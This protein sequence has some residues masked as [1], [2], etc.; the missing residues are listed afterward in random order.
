M[1]ARAHEVCA[2]EHHRQVL[3][4]T[5]SYESYEFHEFEVE[6]L[7]GS[8]VSVNRDELLDSSVS[9]CRDNSDIE[10]A[11]GSRKSSSD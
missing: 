9:A 3:T 7:H 6:Q 5:I 8:N 2:R 4:F 11:R 1:R 10:R